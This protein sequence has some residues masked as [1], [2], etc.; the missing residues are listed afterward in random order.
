ME[1]KIMSVIPLGIILFL[2]LTSKD[3]MDVLYGNPFGVI[4]MTI[5]LMG[6]G[7][8]L[9]MAEKIMKVQV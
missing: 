4:C 5:C 7:V 2:R 1:Q 3:Y 9:F 8:A 6:Y